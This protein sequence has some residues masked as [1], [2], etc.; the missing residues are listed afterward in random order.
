[1]VPIAAK[2]Q[3]PS[4]SAIVPKRDLFANFDRMRRE[5]DEL[6]GD[7]LERSGLT[8]RSGGFAPAVDVLYSADPP[9]VIVIAE[10]A[11]VDPAVLD[12]EI[13]GR[14]LVV[15]GRRELAAEGAVYTI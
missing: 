14:Q 1:M 12:V 7:V 9:R 6:F 4:S 13:H 10:L 5:L 2:P 3:R 8:R 11:G 15:T